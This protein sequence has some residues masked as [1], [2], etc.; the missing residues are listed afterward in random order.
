MSAL[1]ATVEDGLIRL[2][3]DHPPVNILT[4]E[5][6]RELREALHNFSDHPNARVV[7]LSAAGRHFS[8]GADVGEHLP[9]HFERLIPEFLE[10]VTTLD[11]FPLP[12]IA[13]VRGRC[14]GGGFELALAADL[15]LASDTASFGQ[16]EIVLG[17]APPAAAAWLPGRCPRGVAAD[18][19][20]TGDPI[21]A[22]EAERAGLVRRVVPDGELEA[23]ATAL[24]ARLTRHSA[25]ALR[26]VK[27]MM[28]A[29]RDDL[30]AAAITAAGHR[31]VHSL[32][33]TEDAVTGLR[34]FVEKR[35]PVW[36]HR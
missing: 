2:V 14:L 11:R 22:A 28:R 1:H 31:Y 26:E 33:K 34:A 9:P 16:P 23:Q 36:S 10:T 17:V 15:I 5:V 19:L 8:A 7:L 27:Q 25:A 20:F 30:D 13:A 24:A 6:L 4:R 35:A 29:G 18:L 3:L 12:V 32:M 21:P